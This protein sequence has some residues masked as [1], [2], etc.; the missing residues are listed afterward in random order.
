MHT[1]Y[2]GGFRSVFSDHLTQNGVVHRL[3]PPEGHHQL[4]K[5]ERGNYLLKGMLVKLTDQLGTTTR[6]ELSQVLPIAL[7]AK[8]STVLKAG[9]SA[10]TC[11][12]G[13][14]PRLPGALCDDRN[15]PPAQLLG[16]RD[17]EFIRLQAQQSLLQYEQAESIRA[18]QLCKGPRQ[19]G[20]IF[21]A[22]DRIAFWR[23]RAHSRGAASRSMRPGWT[24]GTFICLDPDQR[25]A[26]RS[27]S[28]WVH[29]GGRMVQVTLGQLRPA[30]GHEHF[31]P[32]D[33]DW[34]LLQRL[35]D[36]PEQAV[37]DGVD[38]REEHTE[39]PLLDDSVEEL[40]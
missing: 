37:Q 31:V 26:G 19:D 12:F 11:A 38:L 34:E 25:Q 14:V 3:C 32:T 30:H 4:G 35:H 20:H 16:A 39:A 17:P 10:F 33:H 9:V 6:R 18:A 36:Q 15:E 5:V 28:A 21:V 1:D 27:A 40:L 2:D 7:H 29:A 13:R 22:G 24:T 8:N 23:S